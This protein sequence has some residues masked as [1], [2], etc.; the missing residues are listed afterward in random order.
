M[1]IVGYWTRK[2]RKGKTGKG[3]IGLGIRDKEIGI[4]N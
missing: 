4:R 1:G 3:G 2:V